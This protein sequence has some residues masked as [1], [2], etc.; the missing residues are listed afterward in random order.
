M[1]DSNKTEQSSSI[2]TKQVWQRFRRIAQ[3]YW[4]SDAKWTAW[5]LL[6]ILLVLLAAVNGLNIIINYVGGAWMTAYSAKDVPT[7]YHMMFMYFGV[8]VVGT[9]VVVLYSWMNS[10]LGNH[11]RQWLTE[12]LTKKY[13]ANRNYYRINNSDGIDNPDERLAQ[14]VRDFT[15]GALTLVLAVLSS[16]IT[17]VSFSTILWHISHELVSI[18]IGYSVV[19]TGVTLLLGK[20]LVKLKFD[21]LRLEADYRFN[22]IHVRNNT[23]SIAFYRGEEKESVRIQDRFIKAIKNFNLL[24]GWQRNLGFVTTYYS[25]LVV[26]I[27]A[28]IIAPL[29]FSG[30]VPFGVQTQADMALGQILSALSLIVASF[31]T[32]T[33][34]IAQSNRLGAFNEALE[35]PA[36]GN[37]GT[38]S[39]VT[40]AAVDQLGHR[41]ELK[42]VT[43]ETPRH[44]R[45][46]LTGLTMTIKPGDGGLL[47]VGP[48]GS[49]KSSLLRAI[50]GLWNAGA[51]EIDRPPLEEMMFLPQRPYMVLGTLRQQLL[52]PNTRADVSDADLT[53]ALVDVNLPDLAKRV[54]GF[55][56]ELNWGDVLSLGE[57]QRLAFARLLLSTPKFAILDESTSALDVKN[58]ERLY[59]RLN[60]ESTALISV[61]HRPTLVKYHRQVLE[62][63]GDG[64]WAIMTAAEYAAKN[65]QSLD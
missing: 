58:E 31:D 63:T 15:N 9:P 33:A 30:K 41:I 57:Q 34:F 13:F 35:E 14:D 61:G 16:L 5:G 54:G 45:T 55:D 19:G 64:G 26:L 43:L 10:K 38:I 32:I 51:G 56:I 49:G 1:L 4:V 23:E 36:D 6:G 8:F 3:P 28:L 21:Q 62:L 65:G 42:N 47:I 40:E 27:P 22:L 46:L 11:W 20:R 37:G 2:F 29:Y 24:I 12:H 25:Y 48:S 44:E 17:L 7:F 50:A 59:R 39:D 53:Q 60:T 52:Y 18:V